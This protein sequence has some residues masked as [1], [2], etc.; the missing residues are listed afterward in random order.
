MCY[1]HSLTAPAVLHG[2]CCERVSLSREAR[3]LDGLEPPNEDRFHRGIRNK[4]LLDQLNNSVKE[5]RG[6]AIKYSVGCSDVYKTWM[7]LI[8][9]I[10][11]P[12]TPAL[13]FPITRMNVP[14]VPMGWTAH[15]ANY[16][17]I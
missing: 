14:D 5:L 9:R 7:F 11:V 12:D 4:L 10:I 13:L 16:Q 1:L 6:C 15:T 17:R 8:T 2:D 3:A